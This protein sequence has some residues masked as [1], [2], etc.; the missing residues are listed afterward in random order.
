MK[1]IGKFTIAT[2]LA[3]SAAA[4]AF[5]TEAEDLTLSERNTYLFTADARPIQ[6]HALQNVVRG[7]EA[8]AQAP[9]AS[10][11]LSNHGEFDGY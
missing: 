1:T 7:G 9:A 6:Q 2:L 10:A 8:F 5:A 4:P 11:G 3:L